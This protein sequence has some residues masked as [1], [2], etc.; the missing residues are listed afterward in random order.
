MEAKIMEAFPASLLFLPVFLYI[1]GKRNIIQKCK[2][3]QGGD[4]FD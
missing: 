1:Y 4:R 3:K 2:R